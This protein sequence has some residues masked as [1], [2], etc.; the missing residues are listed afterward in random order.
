M[1][2]LMSGSALSVHFDCLTPP[3][4]SHIIVEVT[5]DDIW[6][7]VQP[8]EGR[9]MMPTMKKSAM[10]V[11]LENLITATSPEHVRSICQTRR[12]FKTGGVMSHGEVLLGEARRTGA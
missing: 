12:D 7:C 9:W 6:V 2:T 10:R 8:N 1:P 4:A 11:F 5:G 3:R